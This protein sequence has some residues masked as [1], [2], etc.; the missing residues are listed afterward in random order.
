MAPRYAGALS[1][2]NEFLPRKGGRSHSPGPLRKV[3]EESL[4]ENLTSTNRMVLDDDEAAA[5][6]AFL[7]Q[8]RIDR[9]L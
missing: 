8:F 5:S 1:G 7:D 4:R 9:F 2:T 6:L 3:Q